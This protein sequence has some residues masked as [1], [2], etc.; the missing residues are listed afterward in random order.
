MEDR[1]RLPQAYDEGGLPLQN[2]IPTAPPFTRRGFIAS[3]MTHGVIRKS[4]APNPDANRISIHFR[5]TKTLLIVEGT[6]NN[7]D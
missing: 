7:N 5:K 3:F 6:K 4:Y 2:L 1:T